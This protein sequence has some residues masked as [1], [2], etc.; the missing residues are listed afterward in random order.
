MECAFCRRGECRYGERCMRSHTEDDDGDEDD[1]EI[2][3]EVDEPN[4]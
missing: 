4:F 1:N 2:A 3:A